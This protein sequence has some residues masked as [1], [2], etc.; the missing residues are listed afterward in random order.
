MDA[1]QRRRRLLR[2]SAR[3]ARRTATA[4]GAAGRR[5][6][7]RL[8]YRPREVVVVALLATGLF[9]GL[10]TERWRVR[11]PV[12]ADRLETEPA[13][14]ASAAPLQS[15][16]RGRSRSAPARCEE[17]GSRVSRTGW[18]DAAPARPRLDLNRATPGELARVAGISWRLAARIV[19]AREAFEGREDRPRDPD[20][21]PRPA[22]SEPPAT[23]TEHGSPPAPTPDADTP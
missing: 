12:I 14:P 3:T 21:D 1:R 5:L 15:A 13:R 22:A 8:A 4:L 6:A 16:P 23:D 2:R 10:A 20:G 19:A 9:G 18:R 7:E 17:P 11:H